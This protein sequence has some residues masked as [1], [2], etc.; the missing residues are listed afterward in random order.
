[1]GRNELEEVESMR[2]LEKKLENT[3]KE[4]RKIKIENY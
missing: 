3:E 4:L 1:M 2:N